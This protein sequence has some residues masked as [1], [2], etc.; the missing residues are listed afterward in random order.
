MKALLKGFYAKATTPELQNYIEVGFVLLSQFQ[1]GVGPI[2]SN[3]RTKFKDKIPTE[4]ELA[5]MQKSTEWL[6]QS[7]LDSESLRAEW[8]QFLAGEPI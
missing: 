6:A 8:K 2:P 5:E 7:L 1:E 4:A 3:P